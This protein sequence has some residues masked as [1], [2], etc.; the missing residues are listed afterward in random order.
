MQPWAEPEASARNDADLDESDPRAQLMA[1]TQG[2]LLAYAIELGLE[3]KRS[4]AKPVLVDMVLTELARR[5]EE[6]RLADEAAATAA[7][8]SSSGE[9]DP[10][11][12]GQAADDPGATASGEAATPPSD[13]TGGAIVL[14]DLPASAKIGG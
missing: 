11:G 7:A 10:G 3:P 4:A 13:G 14:G 12:S 6:Q 5:A 2:Q 1:G 9:S 8:A